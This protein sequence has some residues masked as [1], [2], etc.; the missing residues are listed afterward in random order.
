LEKLIL[1][2]NP[3]SIVHLSGISNSG[4]AFNNVIETLHTNGLAAAHLCDII[5]NNNLKTKLF[6]ASSSEIYKGHVKYNVSEDDTNMFHLHPYSIGK[7]LSHN[8][9]KFYRT[10]KNMPFSNGLLFT[11]ESKEKADTF[12]LNKVAKHIKLWKNNKLPLTVG[13][14]DSYRTILHGAD[15]AKAIRKVIEQENGDDYIICNYGSYKVIDLVT[16]LFKIAGINIINENNTIYEAETMLPIIIMKDFN[17]GFDTQATDITG[18]PFKLERLGW[19][20]EITV[21]E[22]LN[23][24]LNK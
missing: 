8:T 11:I 7:I 10:I 14:L 21:D 2:I 22:I 13:Q 24:I 15:A 4:Y 5:Y 16:K 12:L 9:V 18:T 3:Q 17:T 6:N 23:E 20:P 19:K 1:T